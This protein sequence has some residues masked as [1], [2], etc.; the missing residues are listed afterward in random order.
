MNVS[1]QTIPLDGKVLQQEPIVWVP[2]KSTRVVV[3]AQT[4]QQWIRGK[5]L[6]S[7]LR[8]VLKKG[9]RLYSGPKGAQVGLLLGD[10]E[11]TPKAS[12]N[13][14]VSFEYATPFRT[15]SPTLVLWASTSGFRHDATT[16]IIPNQWNGKAGT[17]LPPLIRRL[18]DYYYLF[19]EGRV[20]GMIPITKCGN[21]P[22]QVRLLEKKTDKIK[23]TLRLVDGITQK[24][25]PVLLRGWIYFAP[26]P[27]RTWGHPPVRPNFYCA[28][29]RRAPRRY[30]QYADGSSVTTRPLPLYLSPD[31]TSTPVGVL[32]EDVRVTVNASTLVSRGRHRFLKVNRS[33][34]FYV[35]YHPRL[36]RKRAKGTGHK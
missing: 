29:L 1:G 8:F 35:P 24:L 22:H 25:G 31:A 20:Q 12:Q 4:H 5:V 27:K 28:F 30:W 34:L 23:V 7:Q 13:H 6:V 3:V 21:A 26:K 2:G 9:T 11:V 18:A 36:F 16:S 15:D 10:L 19:V 32:S 17:S 33:T 14:R